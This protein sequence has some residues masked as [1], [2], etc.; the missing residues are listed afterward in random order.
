MQSVRKDEEQEAKILE[1]GHLYLWIGW[2]DLR[3]MWYGISAANLVNPGKRSWSYI[4]VKITFFVYQS[5]YS[6]C[7]AMASCAT[8]HTTVCLDTFNRGLVK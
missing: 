1:F 7:D 8:R 4:G 6:W 3:Q 2:H 5:I